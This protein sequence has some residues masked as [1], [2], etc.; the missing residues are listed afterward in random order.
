MMI[1]QLSMGMWGTYAN[2]QDDIENCNMLMNKIV[3]IYLEYTKIKE[4]KLEEILSHDIFFTAK[5]CLKYGLV[6][7]II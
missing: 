3:E 1:H 2:M 7:K 4:D 5:Q 6:D